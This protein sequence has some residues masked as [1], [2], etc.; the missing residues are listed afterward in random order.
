MTRKVFHN[1]FHNKSTTQTFETLHQFLKKNKKI[2]KQMV[3][4]NDDIKGFFTAVPHADILSSF[5]FLVAKYVERFVQSNADM[6]DTWITVDYDQ[7]AK[8]P[9]TIQ[10]KAIKT[11]TSVRFRII[12]IIPLVT[13]C[14]QT[15]LFTSLGKVHSQIRGSCIGNP[16]SPPVSEVPIAF[17]EYMWQDIF[18]VIITNMVF[19]CRYV[20][21]RLLCI[22]N[23]M[24]RQMHWKIL[25]D[26]F[27]YDSP[28]ELEKEPGM[29]FLGFDINVEDGSVQYVYPSKTWH[30][31]SPKSAG[32]TLIL[33]SGLVSRIH[34]IARHS[35]PQELIVP[36][37]KHLISLYINLGFNQKDI[38]KCTKRCLTQYSISRSEVLP[39]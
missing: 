24:D 37:V 36:T 3:W 23:Y 13:L 14:L 10:G 28:I 30:F 11:K 12:D 31:R 8:R 2:L 29:T 7:P 39:L 5:E 27:F 4:H 9:R 21:N 16:A 17:K 22:P 34:L 1:T 32:K 26:L 35:Y 18:K 15:S 6:K 25:T 19:A 33:L 38:F 20:D